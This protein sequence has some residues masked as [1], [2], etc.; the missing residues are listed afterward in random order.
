VETER[1]KELATLI[2][3]RLREACG[4]SPVDVLPEAIMLRLELLRQAEANAGAGAVSGGADAGAAQ[5][6]GQIDS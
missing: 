4:T 5:Q 1:N 6:P 3:R 2:G